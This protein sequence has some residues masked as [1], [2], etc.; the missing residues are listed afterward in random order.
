MTTQF[1]RLGDL[2]VALE[3]E[4][5]LVHTEWR[6]LFRGSVQPQLPPDG[7]VA[8][9]LSLALVDALEPRPSSPPIFTDY[10]FPFPHGVGTLSVHAAGE[11][12]VLLHFLEGAAI[13]TPVT[14]EADAADDVPTAHGVVSA[15]IFPY[16]RF[17]DAVFVSLA[18]MMRRLGTY[19]LHASAVAKAGK[20]VLFV[21]RSRSGKTTTCLK[22]ASNGWQFLCNDIVVLAHREGRII[23]WPTP[24]G[25]TVRQPSLA[26]LPELQAH[27]ALNALPDGSLEYELTSFGDVI[28]VAKTALPVAAI[29]FPQVVDS[30]D[31]QVT[32][33]NSAVTLARMMEESVD[34]WD[35]G[36]MGSHIQFLS[37]LAGQT[38]SFQLKLGT[39]VAKLPQLLTQLVV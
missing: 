5:D 10:D 24:D 13:T 19:F 32:R 7:R 28:S 34:S 9:R 31:S 6:T 33:Q 16:G 2:W 11:G 36:S 37:E 26:L 23:A 17:E 14:H 22:L 1:L 21:G 38:T 39:D 12:R 15:A 4:S 30:V 27:L 20:A 3:S 29:C 8:M 35:S 25:I 18:P